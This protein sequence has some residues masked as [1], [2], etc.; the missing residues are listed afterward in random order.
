MIE[1]HQLYTKKRVLYGYKL[2]IAIKLLFGGFA[3]GN[4]LWL[5]PH[6]L[7]RRPISSR[8]LGRGFLGQRRPLGCR[9]LRRRSFL[10]WSLDIASLLDSLLGNLLRSLGTDLKQPL[11]SC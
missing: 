5:S 4:T 8:F 9:L 6:L 10:G 2:H 3:L 7:G 11:R 1:H